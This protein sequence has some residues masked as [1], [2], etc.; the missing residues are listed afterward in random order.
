MADERT[1][2]WKKLFKK[3]CMHWSDDQK[4][5]YLNIPNDREEIDEIELESS[6][7]LITQINGKPPVE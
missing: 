7:D 1:E 5:R 2:R 4:L 6:I 3:N